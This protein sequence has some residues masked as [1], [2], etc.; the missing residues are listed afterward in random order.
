MT[1]KAFAVWFAEMRKWSPASF[2]SAGWKWDASV[3][4]PLS[5]AIERKSISVDKKTEKLLAEHF[6]TVRFGGAIEPRDLDGDPAPKGSL[7]WAEAGDLIYSKID[8]RNGAIGI[9]PKEFPRVAVTS[10]FPVYQVRRNDV[11][12]EY[13]WLVFQTRRFLDFINGMVSGASGRKR[14][15]PD[16]LESVE[17]P[18]PDKLVQQAIVDQWNKAVEL[19]EEFESELGRISEQLDTWLMEQTNAAFFLRPWLALNWCDLK[20][21]DAKTARAA[22]FQLAHPE[23]VPFGTYAEEATK[24]VKPF[25][26]PKHEWAVYG[27]NNKEG[28]F[29]SHKQTG[30]EFNAPY[31]RIQKDWFFHNPTRSSVGSLG[32]VPE[33]PKDAIT[34]PEYQVW[35]LRDLGTDS[36]PPGFVHVLIR[37]KWFVRVI[38][39]HRVGAVKQRLYV[40][41]L[42]EMRV[43]KFPRDLQERIAV[44]RTAALTKLEAARKRAEIVKQEVEEMIL[45]VRPVPTA[46]KA[47]G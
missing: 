42:L 45:G 47:K 31:K 24:M 27:V 43:P 16:E 1:T 25:L 22:A 17:I 12:P 11:V 32:H 23:F 46:T 34:S 6:V 2:R 21:W 44:A 15:Q 40:E 5:A 36:L 26:C 38:Q 7:F 10:E 4:K 8:C 3:I 33:V 20:R 14:V 39:F 30:A 41:N 19:V 9:I 28:V 37:T 35:K 13:I 29:F 18:I